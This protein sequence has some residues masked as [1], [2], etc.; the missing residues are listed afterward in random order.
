MIL[1]SHKGINFSIINNNAPINFI[2]KNKNEYLLKKIRM[3]YFGW[4]KY[5][6]IYWYQKNY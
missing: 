3:I 6:F 4:K 5:D 2:L 1:I